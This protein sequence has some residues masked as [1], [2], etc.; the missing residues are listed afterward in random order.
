MIS[1]LIAQIRRLSFTLI[2]AAVS[3]I[4]FHVTVT[5]VGVYAGAVREIEV[6]QSASEF[7]RK[8]A[9][10][11]LKLATQVSREKSRRLNPTLSALEEQQF[12]TGLY[13]QSERANQP[14]QFRIVGDAELAIVVPAERSG[15]EIQ[16]IRQAGDANFLNVPSYDSILPDDEPTESEDL[17][18]SINEALD[19]WDGLGDPSVIYVPSSQGARPEMPHRSFESNNIYLAPNL[20]LGRLGPRTTTPDSLLQLKASA[21]LVTPLS[22]DGTSIGRTPRFGSS[23][24]TS[25]SSSTDLEKSIFDRSRESKAFSD[26]TGIWAYEISLSQDSA[27]EWIRE[28]NF[29]V[30]M[31]PGTPPDKLMV[32]FKFAIP[33]TALEET[34]FFPLKF[35]AERIARPE[36]NTSSR[37]AF[38]NLTA[39]RS[40]YGDL[41]LS[42]AAIF[43]AR[44][45]Q[46]KSN[47]LAVFGVSVPGIILYNAAPFLILAIQWFYLLHLR[48]LV[49]VL[50]RH[51]PNELP[52]KTWLPLFQGRIAPAT[53]FLMELT[54][55]LAIYFLASNAQIIGGYPAIVL[56]VISVALV[57][58]CNRLTSIVRRDFGMKSLILTMPP[59]IEFS[60]LRILKH[61]VL[62]PGA[63]ESG[64]RH[65]AS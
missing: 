48:A 13:L 63:R 3:L 39:L 42:A 34:P 61:R 58:I 53:C 33:I 11:L 24:N 65:R 14:I 18:V 2:L 15:H 64:T 10:W 30:W 55:S 29:G 59:D 25:T 28:V 49:L 40:E 7:T 6:L 36:L 27:L 23:W 38:P 19:Y 47:D 17:F 51:P 43:F 56:T 37:Y 57:L 22:D 4:L 54:S 8:N 20:S 45:G 62:E 50:R 21:A 1:E 32:S 9:D 26:S 31:P 41:T 52:S 46:I 60:D 44:V 16:V 12:P 5:L 35:L